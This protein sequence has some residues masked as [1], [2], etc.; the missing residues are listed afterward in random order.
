L[1]VRGAFASVAGVGRTARTTLWV[2]AVLL[3]AGNGRAEPAEVASIGTADAAFAWHSDAPE[4]TR[5]RVRPADGEKEWRVFETD[6]GPARHH[7]LEVDGLAPG[8]RYEYRLGEGEHGPRGAL[9]T[10]DPPPGDPVGVLWVLADLHL[11]APEVQE[12]PDG[13]RR[14][15]AADRIYAAAL[16]EVRER[17]AALPAALPQAIVVLG[18]FAQRPVPET[19]RRLRQS[20]TGGLPL[21]LVP[22]NHDGWDRNWA[23]RFAETVAARD[24]AACRYDGV[25]GELALGPWRILLL[26]TVVTGENWGELGD[27]QREWLEERLAA[28]PAR[29]T[30]LALHHPWLPHPLST[31]LGDAAAYARIRD[32]AALDAVLERHPQVRGVLSGHLH[33]NWAG[34]R[35]AVV[36]HIF[37]ATSQFPVGYHS[38]TLY[39]EGLVRRFHPLAAGAE[40]SAASGEA[41]RRWAEER[42]VPLPGA[43][44]GVVAG[45]TASRSG[46]QLLA[47]EQAPS[48]ASPADGDRSGVRAGAPG[49]AAGAATTGPTAPVP[50]AGATAEA[51]EDGTRRRDARAAGGGCRCALPAVQSGNGHASA[52]VAAVVLATVLAAGRR[53]R[54]RGAWETDR[55]RR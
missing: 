30:L 3:A 24:D 53:R 25:R 49:T 20:D 45:D 13:V 14:L 47:E 15:S 44:P 33:V 29:P 41:L 10:R 12:C 32:A 22:G 4:S 11:C 55:R 54:N 16:A 43:V 34:K 2:V 50:A 7:V 40:Q 48:G 38:L 39:A 26:A 5:V 8:T 36:Q 1:I 23:E 17:A 18:D 31:L 27:E 28:E 35:G 6:G 51:S 9:T 19:W 46:V 42:G 21:C 37:S 52:P